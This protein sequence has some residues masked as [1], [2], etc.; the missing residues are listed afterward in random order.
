M[1]H[2][3]RL[4]ERV[5]LVSLQPRNEL[6]STGYCLAHPG[7]EYLVYQPRKSE[8]FSVELK[9]GAYLFEWFDPNKGVTAG[10][11]RIEAP[12]GQQQFKAP[13]ARDAVLHLKRAD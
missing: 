6:A 1:G 5:N 9:P 13:S 8:P 3:R 4:A 12:G 2:T 11:G 7:R 10:K